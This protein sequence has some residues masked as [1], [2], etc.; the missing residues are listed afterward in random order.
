VDAELPGEPRDPT[1]GSVGS[2][3][4]GD[5]LGVEPGPGLL[6]R[7]LT[8]FTPHCSWQ[9]QERPDVFYLVRGV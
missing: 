1:T 9:L 2:D 3:E 4:L 8:A 6:R 7:T 5:P